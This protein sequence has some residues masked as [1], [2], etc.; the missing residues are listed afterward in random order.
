MQYLVF[1]LCG[2]FRLGLLWPNGL[3]ILSNLSQTMGRSVLIVLV[4]SVLVKQNVHVGG[5]VFFLLK[6]TV[7][8]LIVIMY[9]CLILG[10]GTGLCHG[11]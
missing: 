11:A 4:Y 1:I 3:I 2:L 7:R 6:L 9:Y 8:T 10:L 5:M